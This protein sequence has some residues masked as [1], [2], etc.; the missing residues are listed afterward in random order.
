MTA[1]LARW[2][3]P[4]AAELIAE[5]ILALVEARHPG[6]WKIGAGA[7]RQTSAFEIVI[8]PCSC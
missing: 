2:E 1:A 3:A 5:R 7:A 6:R 4:H 8:E